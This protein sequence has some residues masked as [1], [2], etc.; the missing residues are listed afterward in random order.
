VFQYPTNLTV[1]SKISRE[2]VYSNNFEAIKPIRGIQMDLA[3]NDL[4]VYF[5]KETISIA[6]LKGE[7]QDAWKYYLKKGIVKKALANCRT[8][9]QKAYVSGIYAEQLFSG[10]RYELA[11]QYYAR[12]HFSFETVTLKFLSKS[13][14]MWLK[15]YLE[16]VLKLY[17]SNN[18]QHAPQR[19]LL[20]T[21]IVELKLSEINQLNLNFKNQVNSGA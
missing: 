18:P 6:N 20:C 16:Q 14:E 7:D 17:A 10:G 4:M 5:P 13:L 12:S 3:A 1:V 21:W 8:P 19:L 11:A 15:V 9:K 2:I